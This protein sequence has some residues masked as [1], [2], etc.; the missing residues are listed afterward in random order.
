MIWAVGYV[1][2]IFVCMVVANLLYDNHDLSDPIGFT[3]GEWNMV[4]IMCATLWPVVLPI[5]ILTGLAY[6]TYL[7]IRKRLDSAIQAP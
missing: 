6:L 3:R 2:G 7:W 5:A 1:I 4:A